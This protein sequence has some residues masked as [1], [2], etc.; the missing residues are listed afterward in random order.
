MQSNYF[1][2]SLLFILILSF[3]YSTSAS[4]QFLS[5]ID[6]YSL[7]AIYRDNALSF[8]P[9]AK[10]QWWLRYFSG[11]H[12]RVVQSRPGIHVQTFGRVIN[13]PGQIVRLLDVPVGGPRVEW[14]A[15]FDHGGTNQVILHNLLRFP[16]QFDPPPIKS[17]IFD[18]I[19][20]SS[21]DEHQIEWV[22]AFRPGSGPVL[23]I[24]FYQ[25]QQGG[26]Q[27]DTFATIPGRLRGYNALRFFRMGTTSRGIVVATD[28]VFAVLIPKNATWR[29]IEIPLKSQFA[30][31]VEIAQ[32]PNLEPIWL[33]SKY[34]IQL[35]PQDTL[36]VQEVP[37]D[38]G[39]YLFITQGLHV[40]RFGTIHALYEVFDQNRRPNLKYFRFE[41]NQW[42]VET[43]LSP[44]PNPLQSTLTTFED[45]LLVA[46][47]N[48]N[49]RK[50]LLA[51]RT[52]ENIWQW[53][54]LDKAAD[55]ASE[56]EVVVDRRN[57]QEAAAAYFDRTHGDLKVAY[58]SAFS[59]ETEPWRVQTVDTLGNVDHFPQVTTNV[60]T[61]LIVYFDS[62]RGWLKQA[63]QSPAGFYSSA[64]GSWEISKIDS[65]GDMPV[66]FTLTG[67]VRENPV[68]LAYYNEAEGVIKY[69]LFTSSGW[70][71]ENIV[72][73]DIQAPGEVSLVRTSTDTLYVSYIE[74]GE[75]KLAHRVAPGTPWSI[76][77]VPTVASPVYASWTSDNT[78]KLQGVYRIHKGFNDEL[79][80]LM[81]TSSGWSDQSITLLNSQGTWLKLRH[82]PGRQNVLILV[83]SDDATAQ[84]YCYGGH[85]W[86]SVMN[87]TRFMG[88]TQ[89]DFTLVD[90][91][92]LTLFYRALD[93][94]GQPFEPNPFPELVSD[95]VVSIIDVV[96]ERTEKPAGK[97][98]ASYP[99]PFN[100]QTTLQYHVN[101]TGLVQIEIYDILGR[102]VKKLLQEQQAPG[103]YRLSF[104][105]KDFASGVYLCRYSI[106]GVRGVHKLVVVK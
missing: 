26:W 61:T 83:F 23:K 11:T 84:A 74:G 17:P 99:N 85:Q 22:S 88:D 27:A 55:L 31:K 44:A 10:D 2:H 89:I 62:T 91:Y 96:R 97:I 4:G 25:F 1:F 67:E 7:P 43:I 87:G 38:S 3:C 6:G 72:S 69:G 58:G 79:R 66:P 37:V 33:Y 52:G 21:L 80:H 39:A 12:L 102:K 50:I 42:Q 94:S 104:S 56:L 65:V 30:K 54:V 86:I 95:V 75:L 92:T 19:A 28:T 57:F 20:H 35:T 101:K 9:F 77:L 82:P 18:A 78:G 63:V 36:F 34:L 100:S 15:F 60:D 73:A 46:I 53:Q 32:K 71:L 47:S 93:L 16:F 45:T 29:L 105:A 70:Q 48:F 98:L 64:W 106:A 51:K 24:V 90:F 14:V 13:S 49:S 41:N 59:F 5:V 40:D 103:N 81:K 68:E 76:E 8:D